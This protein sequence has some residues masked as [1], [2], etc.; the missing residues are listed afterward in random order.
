[1]APQA[2]PIP[3]LR[4]SAEVFKGAGDRG[5]AFGGA[6]EGA[7]P[8]L[9]DE[10]AAARPA[11]E[12]PPSVEGQQ[13]KRVAATGLDSF[14]LTQAA[15]GQVYIAPPGAEATPSPEAGVVQPGEGPEP[16]PSFIS[17]EWVY[18]IVYKVV[19]KMAPPMLSPDHIAALI[20]ELTKEITAELN[21][22]SSQ[23]Y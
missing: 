9:I 22:E 15:Q 1:L 11:S 14:S 5:A 18:V 3:P 16:S 13:P 4:P 10:L 20:R 7:G 21:S 17:Q 8:M 6:A 2:E 23:P 19:M 12:L